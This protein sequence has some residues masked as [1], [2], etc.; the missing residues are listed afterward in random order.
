MAESAVAQR[1]LTGA[2]LRERD[3]VRILVFP[4]ILLFMCC[5]CANGG[6]AGLPSGIPGDDELSGIINPLDSTCYDWRADIVPCRFR[7]PYAEL[8][9][10]QP[11]TDSRLVDNRDGTVTDLL[12][13]LVWL[14]N[15]N[16]FGMLDWKSAALAAKG[17]KTGNCGPDPL[18]VLSDG[19][20]TGDWRLPTM[21]EL[22]TL[23]DFGRRD[24]AL[25]Q[26]HMFLNVPSGYH[27]SAT[28]LEHYAGAAWIVYVESGTTCY[29][30]INH[31]AGHV[32]PVREPLE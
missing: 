29:E 7:R 20:S 26:G 25:P 27:W 16:C 9:L 19:S 32:W 4:V 3:W 8:L 22:C 30:G 24:P 5:P 14:K 31:R 17:L 12:T 23:I 18:L 11:V 10:D 13:G 1:D 15:L 28:P 2:C 21:Q 6:E